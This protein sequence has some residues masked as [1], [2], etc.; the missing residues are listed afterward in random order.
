MLIQDGSKKYH[1][2]EKQL[3]PSKTRSPILVATVGVVDSDFEGVEISGLNVVASSII[4]D[5]IEEQNADIFSCRA[6]DDDSIGL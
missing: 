3:I 5:D 6:I 4:F 2:H 1:I